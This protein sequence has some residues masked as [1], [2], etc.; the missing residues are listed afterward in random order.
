METDYIIVGA[1]IAGV[2]LAYE[3]TKRGKSS[4]IFDS[5]QKGTSSQ[6]AAG[7][8]NPIV[9]KR[10]IPAWRA[11]EIFPGIEKY[12]TEFGEF[13]KTTGF[14]PFPFYQI[15]PSEQEQNLWKRQ[16]N[17]PQNATFLKPG[18]LPTDCPIKAQYGVTEILQCGRVLT[19]NL[20]NSITAIWKKHG[21]FIADDFDYHNLEILADGLRY[22]GISASG[23][24]FCEGNGVNQ[25][26]WFSHIAVSS[27]PGDIFR[28]HCDNMS[29]KYILKQKHWCVP[30]GGNSFLTG[31]TF[32]R[33]N[34]LGK[35]E[36]P[37]EEMEEKLRSWLPEFHITERMRGDRPV[38]PDRRP[39]A[40][41]HSEFCNMYVYNGLGT[42]GCSLVTW[43]SGAMA[44]F[45][46]DQVPLPSEVQPDRFL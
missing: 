21:S 39:I 29:E 32:I 31:S 3:L 16:M 7:L 44:D 18:V 4:I 24:V 36:I 1:G 15:H 5:S 8:I 25:N 38:T 34:D 6:I 22:K 11:P 2:T 30:E 37:A 42:R 33:D 45:I 17:D 10:V 46:T 41:Q 12:Y 26:P 43:L 40:G 23:I 9:P 13:A 27:S 20:I 35:S 14:V 19:G 28:I